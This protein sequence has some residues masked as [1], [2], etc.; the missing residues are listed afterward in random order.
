MRLEMK[1]MLV[2]AAAALIVMPYALTQGKLWVAG[3]LALN[4]VLILMS[5]RR[6]KRALERQP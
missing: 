4:V 1:I 6:E 5:Y 2:L 3:L